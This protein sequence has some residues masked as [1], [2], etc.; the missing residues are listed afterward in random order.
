MTSASSSQRA[1]QIH[2]LTSTNY[3]Q[4]SIQLE[5]LLKNKQ[6]GVTSGSELKPTDIAQQSAWESKD[7]KARCEILLHCSP[8]QLLW[9][10]NLTTSKEVWD[11]LKAT[12][13]NTNKDSQV[14]IHKKLTH[15]TLSESSNVI[16]FLEE[17][18]SLVSEA[19]LAGLTLSN[20][21]QV[22][23]LLAALPPS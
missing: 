23:L 10:R 7:S 16:S 20:D 14:N 3:K 12:Y 2:K 8:T 22:I 4:W 9:M 5:V 13:A 19:S 1:Y 17:W 18:Q 6:W 15:F 21:Q 11:L